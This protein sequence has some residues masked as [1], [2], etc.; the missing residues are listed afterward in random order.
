MKKTLSLFALLALS[1]ALTM[2]TVAEVVRV[3]LLADTFAMNDEY[4]T[5]NYAYAQN[6]VAGRVYDQSLSPA[7]MVTGRTYLKYDLSSIPDNAVINSVTL[8]LY[9]YSA[10]TTALDLRVYHADD[11]WQDTAV[12]WNQQP[13]TTTL[14]GNRVGLTVNSWNSWS[15]SPSGISEDLADNTLSLQIRHANESLENLGSYGYFRSSEY[16]PSSAA[17]LDID[18]SLPPPPPS[19]DITPSVNLLLDS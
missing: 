1:L 6:V 16:S 8:Y 5:N 15:L 2:P 13:G 12:T 4:A 17:A 3:P 11:D 10:K 9:C 14:L 19:K 18:Y 7:R